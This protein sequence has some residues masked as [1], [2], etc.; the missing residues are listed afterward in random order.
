MKPE[1]KIIILLIFTLLLT[2]CSRTV[3]TYKDIDGTSKFILYKHNYKYIENS[4]FGKFSETGAYETTDSLI[5]FVYRNKKKIPYTYQSDNVQIRNRRKNDEYQI[6]H[7][8]EKDSKSPIPFVSV[9]FKDKTG[10]IINGTNTDID[11]IANIKINNDIY[12][13]EIGYIGAFKHE[14]LYNE[15]L[16]YDLN[17]QLEELKPGGRM[18]DGCLIDYIDV[19]LEY[20]IDDPSDFSKLERNGIVYDKQ[21]DTP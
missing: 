15:Y 12:I 3:Y 8:T 19:I 14:F 17:I 21:I 18:S 11:G 4:K 1:C 2:S 9:A 5:S 7:L 16:A 20:K 13:I 6:M 10:K